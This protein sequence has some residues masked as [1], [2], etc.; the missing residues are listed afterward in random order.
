[1]ST[2]KIISNKESSL[3]IDQ[4][5]VSTMHKGELLV[6]HIEPGVYLVDVV[7]ADEE[8]E[9]FDVE[10][11]SDKQQVLKRVVFDENHARRDGS[12]A[13]L[14]NEPR[15]VG[16][17]QNDLPVLAQKMVSGILKY[18][19][20]DPFGKTLIPFVFD[21]ADEFVE[22]GFA[23]AEKFGCRHIIDKRGL[24]TFYPT[25]QEAIDDRE[26][27]FLLPSNRIVLEDGTSLQVDW[28][29]EAK[30]NRGQWLFTVFS[31]GTM[32]VIR[33]SGAGTFGNEKYELIT[34][35]DK[36]VSSLEEEYLIVKKGE[37]LYAF[38]LGESRTTEPENVFSFKCDDL[39]PVNYLSKEVSEFRGNN[40]DTLYR[41]NVP[42][43]FSLFLAKRRGKYGVVDVRGNLVRSFVFDDVYYQS[44]HSEKD[45]SRNGDEFMVVSD[46]LV[47]LV[48][49]DFNELIPPEYLE[50]YAIGNYYCVKR[51]GSSYYILIDRNNR[52]V[53]SGGFSSIIYGDYRSANDIWYDIHFGHNDYIIEKSGKKGV[54][55]GS[56][57]LFIPV[58]YDDIEHIYGNQVQCPEEGSYKEDDGFICKQDDRYGILSPV[59]D[60]VVKIQYEA[61]IP[62][63]HDRDTSY[64]AL[65][66]FA[67]KKNGLYAFAS[68][69]RGLLTHYEYE[70][71][72][73][74][75]Y[76][77]SSLVIPARK[78]GKWGVIRVVYPYDKAPQTI[79]D[80]VYDEIVAIEDEYDYVAITVKQKGNETTI[81][82]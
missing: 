46:G 69:D 35:C 16:I 61:I 32:W 42:P 33:T 62:F 8:V 14:D 18:G 50:M 82:V 48:D 78:N 38:P 29:G 1:M 26:E 75:E 20:V 77:L 19:Y 51:P 21:E 10:L 54:L 13:F 45:Y 76:C 3:Y 12:Q 43:E 11:A 59:G 15:I 36:V 25:I 60:L 79:L 80:F 58:I 30:H 74:C 4:Q 22:E 17:V 5:F 23:E 7:S 70:L 47:G 28:L 39:I 52:E 6:H 81:H 2:L 27:H 68:P 57:R 65:N 67:F 9:S 72:G 64:A 55:D 66:G 34:Q 71:F 56:G 40:F 37:L 24:P 63:V 31:Q 53:Y 41:R 49:A 44:Y 73:D